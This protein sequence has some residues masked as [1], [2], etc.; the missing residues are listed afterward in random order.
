MLFT[1]AALM[2]FAMS[3][4][5]YDNEEELY[6]EYYASQTCDTVSVSYDATIRPIIESTCNTSGC[7]VA[8]GTGNGI[9]TN[10]AGLKAKVDNGSLIDRVVDQRNMPPT[11]SLN[12]CQIKLIS[13]W[14]S[15]GALEN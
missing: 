14:V 10:Y 7:H 3:S 15:Q 9:F 1:A 2:L 4:C 11:T 12:D 6:A 13:A 5:Y 8:G